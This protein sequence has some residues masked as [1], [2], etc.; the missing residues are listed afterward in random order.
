MKKIFLLLIVCMTFCSTTIFAQNGNGQ[1]GNAVVSTVHVFD[2]GNGT[3]TIEV[4]ISGNQANEIRDVA[5]ILTSDRIAGSATLA[6][7]MS[8]AGGG[9]NA[10]PSAGNG[11][12]LVLR[13]D[14]HLLSS[15]GTNG[16]DTY[17]AEILLRDKA[18]R[19]FKDGLI[20]E[21]QFPH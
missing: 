10:E 4:R 9:L 8:R 6:T 20:Y 12:T 3:G 7:D 16:P 17:H 15:P 14:F 18:R 11:N 19:E 5:I 13:G 21:V 2:N 1:Q